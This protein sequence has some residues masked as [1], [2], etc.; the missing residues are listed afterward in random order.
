MPDSTI[1]A[2]YMLA[3]LTG[4]LAN[5]RIIPENMDRNLWGSFGL[6]FSQAVLL[7]LI[8][9]GMDRQ[10]AYEQVQAVAMRCW[11]EKKSFADEVRRDTAISQALG[12]EKL[13][14]LFDPANFLR[15]E[16]LIFERVFGA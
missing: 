3:R 15:Y 6:F 1:L 5:L 2:D 14:R 10:K 9:A 11:N 16:D 7:A 12:A 13:D 8:E 4:L